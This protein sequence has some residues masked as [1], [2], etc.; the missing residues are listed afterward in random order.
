VVGPAA[1]GGTLVDARFPGA[2][3]APAQPAP[4]GPQS[5]RAEVLT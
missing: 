5:P 1:G 4:Q 2:G 3:P